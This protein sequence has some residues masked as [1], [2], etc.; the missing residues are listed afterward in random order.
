MHPSWQRYLFTGTLYK[1]LTL[2]VFLLCITAWLPAQPGCPAGYI[3]KAVLS[4]TNYP[5]LPNSV[6]S[7]SLPVYSLVV[8]AILLA[9]HSTVLRCVAVWMCCCFSWVYFGSKCGICATGDRVRNSWC[10]RVD[11]PCAYLADS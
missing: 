11:C 4:E 1:G 2:L 9:L 8:P 7:W 3:P 6:P 5:L 10:R